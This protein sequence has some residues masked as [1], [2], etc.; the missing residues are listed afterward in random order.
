MS[1]NGTIPRAIHIFPADVS[2]K[3]SWHE[4]LLFLNACP[5]RR[6]GV[7]RRDL[8]FELDRPALKPLPGEPMKTLSGRCAGLDYHFDIDGH[9]YSVPRRLVC[10]Q[11][12]GRITAQTI[13]LFRQRERVALHG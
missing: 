9:C 12:D 5:M 7:S 1:W 2:I 13:E 6:L 3:G 10:E 8:F 4:R 11:L